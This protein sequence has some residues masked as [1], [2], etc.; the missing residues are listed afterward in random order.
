MANIIPARHSSFLARRGL[1]RATGSALADLQTGTFLERAEDEALRSLT[2]AR[3]SD[4]GLATHHALDEADGIIRDLAG[5]VESNPVGVTAL[6]G[7]AEE[8]VLGVRRE[9]RRL[10]QG[11]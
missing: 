2:T 10:A 7:I 11:R 8:G 6:G 9:L 4:L 5:R 3:I 1:D